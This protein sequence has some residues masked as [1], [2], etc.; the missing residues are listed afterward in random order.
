MSPPHLSFIAKKFSNF[1][2]QSNNTCLICLLAKQSR[3]PFSPSVISSIKPFKI[4]HCDIRGCYRHPSFSGAYYFFTIVDDYTCFT[5]IFLM[6]HK[7]ETQSLLKHCFSYVLTQFET[8]IF[9]SDNGGEFISFRSF[10]QDNGVVFQYFCITYLNKMGLW[11]TN[12]VT[13]YK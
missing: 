12:I 6:W 10:F 3:L 11:N 7:D 8:H 2:V 9:K 1:F 13:S 4:I 5:W